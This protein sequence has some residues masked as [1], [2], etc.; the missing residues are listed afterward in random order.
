MLRWNH[1]NASTEPTVRRRP[2]PLRRSNEG[3]FSEG[4]SGAANLVD[5][6]EFQQLR[7]PVAAM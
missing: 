6:A 3:A 1:W 4:G 5:L 2:R 7:Q